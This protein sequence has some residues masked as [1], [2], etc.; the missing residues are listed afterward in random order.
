MTVWKPALSDEIKQE[1]FE[2]ITVPLLQ[3]RCTTWT[4]MKR[5]YNKLHGGDIRMF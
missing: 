4:F 1:F 2:V 5:L 3:Y